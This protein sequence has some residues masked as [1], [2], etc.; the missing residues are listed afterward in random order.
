M[1]AG[2][3]STLVFISISSRE[4]ISKIIAIWLPTM[5]FVALALDHVIANMFFIPIGIW[6]GAPG[7]TVGLYIWKS[8]IPA[9]IGNTVGGGIFV[10]TVYWYLYLTG[11]SSVEMDFNVGGLNTAMEVGG[12]MGRKRSGHHLSMKYAERNRN[13][14]HGED[15]GRLSDASQLPNSSGH[16]VSGIGRELCADMYAKRK[17]EANE[18]KSAG[19]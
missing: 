18:E 4:V 3:K 16:M 14:I 11:E 12:P 6:N 15:P 17:G 8:M 9:V 1:T 5:T 10:A 7:I 13:V 2:S 19:V